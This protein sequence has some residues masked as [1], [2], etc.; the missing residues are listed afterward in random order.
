M[1]AEIISP[2]RNMGLPPLGKALS[3]LSGRNVAAK[4]ASISSKT[5]MW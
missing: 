2:E 5:T 1:I 4:R 3:M